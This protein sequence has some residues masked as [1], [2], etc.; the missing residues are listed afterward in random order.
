MIPR[1]SPA[2]GRFGYTINVIQAVPYTPRARTSRRDEIEHALRDRIARLPAGAPLG[3]EAV[4]CDEFGVSRM[5]VRSALDRVAGDGLVRRIPGRGTFVVGRDAA[6]ASSGGPDALTDALALLDVLAAEGSAGVSRLAAAAGL[7]RRDVEAIVERLDELG[8]VERTGAGEVALGLRLVGLG[9]A[10][11]RRLEVTSVARPVLE[12]VH[13]ATEETVYLCV[14]RGDDAL[15]VDRIDGLWVQSLTL[16]LGETIPL[17]LGAA[18]RVLLAHADDAT[19]TAYLARAPFPALTPRTLTTRA[20]LE[21][22][23]RRIAAHGHAVSDGDIRLGIAAVGAP[24][25]DRTGAVCAA[26]SVG[27]LRP[28]ILDDRAA[29]VALV[30]DGAARISRALGHREARS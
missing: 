14:R 24:I 15:C 22:E 19:R 23:L 27:G 29:T 2:V 28:S 11:A 21:R 13:R 10:A 20:S 30:R 1:P 8:L 4:L 5:T 26:L 12:D 25:R 6:P 17:H 16:R 7:R 18:S 3:T 9:A